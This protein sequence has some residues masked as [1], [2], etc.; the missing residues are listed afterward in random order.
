M[1]T[2]KQGEGTRARLD[3]HNWNFSGV[4]GWELVAATYYEY[5]RESKT[6]VACLRIKPDASPPTI[7]RGLQ[8][9]G[10]PLSARFNVALRE[11]IR[12]QAYPLWA[13]L[14]PKPRPRNSAGTSPRFLP[15]VKPWEPW[16]R[17]AEMTRRA[18]CEEV[19]LCISKD[20]GL[21]FL[22]FKPEKCTKQGLDLINRLCFRA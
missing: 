6:I 5:A 8:V 13:T 10:T 3:E 19:A 1:S 12:L 14:T 15:R 17:I 4:E 11:K 22:P 21:S 16:Q 20:P 7:I 9:G 18:I 2:D